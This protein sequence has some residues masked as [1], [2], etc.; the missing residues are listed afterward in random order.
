[1]KQLNNIVPDLTNVSVINEN[2]P[3]LELIKSANSTLVKHGLESKLIVEEIM[4]TK[5]G[6]QRTNIA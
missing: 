6:Q 3:F 2:D 1:M 5:H 4:S